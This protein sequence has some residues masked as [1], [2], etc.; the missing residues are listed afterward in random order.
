VNS[1][2]P[3]EQAPG[4]T[5]ATPSGPEKISK[6]IRECVLLREQITRLDM[7][8]PTEDND[9]KRDIL[10]KRY[11]EIWPRAITTVE[12]WEAS[13]GVLESS[14][15]HVARAMAEALEQYG[16]TLGRTVDPIIDAIIE[17][18]KKLGIPESDIVRSWDEFWAETVEG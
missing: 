3:A 2:K 5:C 4:G 10:H 16:E 7:L 11:T 15:Q 13:L 6:L 1:E 18:N 9:R 14:W 12:R 8:P 17:R